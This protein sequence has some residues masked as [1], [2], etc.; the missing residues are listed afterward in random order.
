MCGF[1]G[2][3][4]ANHSH[5]QSAGWKEHFAS[6][7]RK[8]AHRGTDDERMISFNA[9]SLHHFRLAFQD[10]ESGRQPMLSK[11]GRLAIT[12][13]GE[14]YNHLELRRGLEKKHGPIGWRTQSDTE[15]LLEG[16]RLEGDIFADELEGEY[17]FVIVQTDGSEFFAARDFFG[18]KPLFFALSDMNTRQF[19]I[20]RDEY[21]IESS[22]LAFA[23]EMKSLPNK[24]IWNRDGALRQFVGLFEPVCTPFENIIQCPAGGRISGKKTSATSA[25]CTFK[26]NIK[27]K[28]T[29]IR[30]RSAG[31]F[32]SN[33]D[34]Q[35]NLSSFRNTF[36]DSVAERLLSDVEL[37]VYLSGG[38]DSKSVAYELSRILNKE[39]PHWRKDALKS[40]TVGFE[41]EGYDESVEAVAFSK[42]LGFNPHVLKVSPD[43]LRYSYEHAVYI[44]ENLQPY[45]NGAAKWWLS[46]FARRS[47][48][49]VLTGDG[50]DEL[51][52]GYPSFRYCAWWAFAQRGRH[53]SSPLGERWRD[54][55]YIKKFNA[56]ARDPWLAGSSAEGRGDD[57]EHSL[58]LWGVAHPLFGQI[59]TITECILGPDEAHQWLASQ[60]ESLRSWFLQGFDSKSVAGNFLTQPEN[61]LL[62][63]QN[64]FCQTHLPVQILNWVGDRMEM[65]NTL[66]GRTP[67]LSG[68]MRKLVHAFPDGALVQGFLDKAI[69]RKAYATELPRQFVMTPKKQ[70]NAP[71]LDFDSLF[72][73]YDVPSLLGKMG[74]SD[75]GDSTSR[76]LLRR[77]GQT[78]KSDASNHERYLHT[79]QMSAMQTLICSAIVQRGLVEQQPAE[80]NHEFEE[81]IL[82]RGGPLP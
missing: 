15:T 60:G 11:D 50:A 76:E 54:S 63:W 20:A 61:A 80:R 72:H 67:F 10:V 59:R 70:F 30:A 27:T 73:Q 81:N 31:A 24:K 74:V 48:A 5:P 46:L 43:A 71:F 40:F 6:A 44:S 23:S 16:W 33:A 21:S 26:I 53:P 34:L 14:I 57:F 7:A 32:W 56:Q 2:L 52:C 41:T 39:K 9:V 51:L 69:L 35:D 4:T 13:N 62:L 55:V 65:A 79:H 19:S 64:Y 3:L 29:P 75:K 8:I 25:N 38:I 37:G 82:S 78:P 45:T 28:S 36:S 47:V 12:F 66:E 17:A 42:Y 18:V 22:L 1:S 58:S 68:R 77:I 49:G